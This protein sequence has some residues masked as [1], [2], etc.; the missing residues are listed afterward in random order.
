MTTAP[1]KDL[2]DASTVATKECLI[3]TQKDHNQRTARREAAP[4]RG[5]M[6]KSMTARERMQRK[7]RTNRGCA[8]YRQRG[9]SVEQCSAR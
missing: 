3:A 5:R 4:P 7:L 2:H 8:L 1:D 6:R 9:A